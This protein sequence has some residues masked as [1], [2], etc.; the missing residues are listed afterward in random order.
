MAIGKDVKTVIDEVGITGVS[1][2]GT[3]I[4]MEYLTGEVE[5]SA[6]NAYETAVD[7]T[8]KAK[9]K[10]ALITTKAIASVAKI[11]GGFGIGFATA[12]YVKSEKPRRIGYGVGIGCMLS[13]VLEA[14]STYTL[15][16]ATAST[17]FVLKGS[18]KLPVKMRALPMRGAM[19]TGRTGYNFTQRP[20]QDVT[21]GLE[22]LPRD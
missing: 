2:I 3:A 7:A 12:K 4:G 8:V 16:T 15:S 19:S 22:I 10:D 14:I 20:I 9:A 11:L 18:S 6:V 17:G 5:K 1:V 13:G 21:S